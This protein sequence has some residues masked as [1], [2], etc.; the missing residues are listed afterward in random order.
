MIR[1]IKKWWLLKNLR[2]AIK[3]H[4]GFSSVESLAMGK[5]VLL[6]QNFLSWEQKIIR[7]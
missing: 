5:K 7:D 4:T 3:L 6:S 1:F 2:K